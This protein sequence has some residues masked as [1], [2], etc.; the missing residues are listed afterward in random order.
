LWIASLVAGHLVLADH[1][2]PSEALFL[3]VHRDLF[4]ASNLEA[5]AHGR[6]GL[7]SAVDRAVLILE[8]CV[9]E[10]CSRGL[11]VVGRASEG[12]G[13]AERRLATTINEGGRPKGGHWQE[14]GDKGQDVGIGS[15]KAGSKLDQG[16]HS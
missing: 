11:A 14:E 7:R 1:A 5:R 10:R 6:D 3:Q 4:S 2:V 16:K 8:I 15:G 13:V 9:L 12:R